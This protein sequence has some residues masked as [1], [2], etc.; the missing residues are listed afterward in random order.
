MVEESQMIPETYPQ[1]QTINEGISEWNGEM[2]NMDD[3]II[4]S[5]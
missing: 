1:Q 2:S 5:P 3:D 4:R